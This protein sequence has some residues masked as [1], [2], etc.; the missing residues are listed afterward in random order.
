LD[1]K[2]PSKNIE[3]SLST[4][5]IASWHHIVEVRCGYS[6]YESFIDMHDCARVENTAA[7]EGQKRWERRKQLNTG[8][9]L[10]TGSVETLLFE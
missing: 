9:F 6:S 2:L 3:F 10:N 4:L 1:K 7:R 5:Q 8:Y